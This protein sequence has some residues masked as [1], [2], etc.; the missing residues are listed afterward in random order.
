MLN[1]VVDATTDHWHLHQ[2]LFGFA[3]YIERDDMVLMAV[4]SKLRWEMPI[5]H[6]RFRAECS[7]GGIRIIT[8]RSRE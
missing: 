6:L 4:P 1:V 3:S 5:A 8:E 7:H 2:E